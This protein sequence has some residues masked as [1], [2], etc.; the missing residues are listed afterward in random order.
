MYCKSIVVF[1]FPP[2]SEI[3]TCGFLGYKTKTC[4]RLLV[5]VG[6]CQIQ[7][8]ST[9]FTLKGLQCEHPS[10]EIYEF[11]EQE[12]LASPNPL[13]SLF[14]L[15]DTVEPRQHFTPTTLK[16]KPTLYLLHNQVQITF[17]SSDLVLRPNAGEK[18]CDSLLFGRFNH[19]NP[20]ML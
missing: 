16:L 4:D 9:I 17:T 7:L 18:L 19:L 2:V 14:N 11:L 8:L 5:N 1:L 6:E 13:F 10:P 20:L 3:L 12:E 15:F